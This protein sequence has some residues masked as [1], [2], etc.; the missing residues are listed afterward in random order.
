MARSVGAVLSKRPSSTPPGAIREKWELYFAA[1][2]QLARV[3]ERIAEHFDDESN[4]GII[5]GVSNTGKCENRYIQ[6]SWADSAYV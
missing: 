3:D 6:L 2:E 5:L 1:E 4:G